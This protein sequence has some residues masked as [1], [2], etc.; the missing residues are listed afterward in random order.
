MKL[1]TDLFT[2]RDGFTFD[3]GRVL[4][5]K[6]AVAYVSLSVWHL[7]HGG[8]FEPVTWAAG[9]GGILAAGGGAL[10]LK[11]GTEPNAP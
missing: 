4:W 8:T 2:G 10:A 11:S 9:A 6:F 5:M 1:L 3:L 7:L